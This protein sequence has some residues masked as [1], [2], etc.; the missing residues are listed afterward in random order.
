[1]RSIYYLIAGSA[2]FGFI[3]FFAALVFGAGIALF[4]AFLREGTY[5]R[6]YFGILA[7]SM[8]VAVVF[9]FGGTVRNLLSGISMNLPQVALCVGFLVGIASYLRAFK[10]LSRKSTAYSRGRGRDMEKK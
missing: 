6:I 9:F 7:L 4:I 5:A 1:M 10:Y 3:G 2:A 8:T